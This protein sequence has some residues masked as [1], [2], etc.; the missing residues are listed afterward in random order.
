MSHDPH[1]SSP[2]HNQP[3]PATDLPEHRSQTERLAW[4]G[5]D[6]YAWLM[7]GLS[8]VVLLVAR[9]FVIPK[10]AAVFSDFDAE[11]PL[12]TRL[13]IVVPAWVWV[14]LFVVLFGTMIVKSVV[15]G[16]HRAVVI[17]DLLIAFVILP[18]ICGLV[19]LA[20]FLPLP[21]LIRAVMNQ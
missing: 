14:L 13:I 3:Q 18:A 21:G 9:A 20:L 7:M 12:L 11:L 15:L 5:V 16:P 10:F 6:F 19:I 17:F 1:P 4:K 2:P 8:M